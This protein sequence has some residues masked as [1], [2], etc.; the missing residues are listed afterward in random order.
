MTNDRTTEDLGA[1]YA[2]APALD[3]ELAC[4][5]ACTSDPGFGL[6]REFLLRQAALLDRL[7]LQ[8]AVM[9]LVLAALGA[10]DR[11]VSHDIE[12]HGLSLRGHDLFASDDHQAYVREEYRVWL[13]AQ[14][15]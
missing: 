4:L 5:R 13:L 14:N 11:L 9:P 2:D 15:H 3:D 7:A 12:H 10:A 6:S 8:G 1:A